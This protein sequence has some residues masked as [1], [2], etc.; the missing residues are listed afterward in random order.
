MTGMLARPVGPPVPTTLALASLKNIPSPSQ[1]M[2][3]WVTDVWGAG[4][5][6]L[7]LQHDPAGNATYP[8]SVVD[9]SLGS[10]QSGSGAAL[11]PFSG[12]WQEAT[13]TRLL[14][15]APGVWNVQFQ[16]SFDGVNVTAY[17]SSNGLQ[18]GVGGTVII[19]G[20][21]DGA[22]HQVTVANADRGSYSSLWATKSGS[23]SGGIESGYWN[24]YPSRIA[25]P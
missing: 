4:V 3:V 15:P 17:W 5:G 8:W 2:V 10:G 16:G 21:Q 22:F 1:G 19:G 13:G 9:H 11:P 7:K 12:S 25:A 18:P 23:G 20:V 24:A 14:L 6:K